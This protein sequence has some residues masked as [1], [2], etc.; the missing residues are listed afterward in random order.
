MNNSEILF[1][2]EA[3]LCNPNGDPDEE[4]KPRMDPKTL[5]N[6]VSDVR[7]KR[8]LRDYLIERYGEKYVWVS[9]VG[10]KHVTSDDR[11]R[12]LLDQWADDPRTKGI[13]KDEVD[14]WV[15]L[16]PKLC[17]DARLFGATVAVRAKEKGKRG[18]SRNFIGP[19]QFT[20]GFSLHPVE[21]VDSSTITSIFVGR[22]ASKAGEE[23]DRYGTMGKDWRVYY[24]LIAFYGVVSG[25]RA[26]ATGLRDKDVRV[27]DNLLWD[28]LLLEAVSRSKIGQRPHLYLRV[29][30][31]DSETLTGDLR[32][33]I[34]SQVKTKNVRSQEDL[35]L[36]Y[37]PLLNA[38]KE[39]R[40]RVARIYIHDG[41]ELVWQEG[42][43]LKQA[44]K[45]DPKLKEFVVEL[46]HPDLK[47]EEVL[48][49]I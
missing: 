33:H 27:L 6:L 5:R 7:L 45:E 43:S 38:I 44:L 34:D 17:I 42:K 12:Y 31:K 30:Y 1:L 14:R 2:Y 24:S 18:A 11:A 36:S 4:N 9:T 19:V 49:A 40:S 23:E 20:W 35:T 48:T 16:V 8:Y 21:L 22:E 46:P 26:E 47:M 41:G 39:A 28:S 13:K 10:G 37:R 3:K 15:A 32:R 25:A 29:E